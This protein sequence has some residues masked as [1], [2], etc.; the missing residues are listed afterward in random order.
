MRL[1]IN[2]EV[3]ET[4]LAGAWVTLICFAIAG[5]FVAAAVILSLILS[6]LGLGWFVVCIV[7]IVLFLKF[8]TTSKPK[9]PKE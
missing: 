3:R 5:T 2:A 7:A 6:Q 4:I 9:Q 8:G 1:E